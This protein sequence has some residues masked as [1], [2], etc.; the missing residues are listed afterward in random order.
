VFDR[1]HGALKKQ[2]EF[3]MASKQKAIGQK[4]PS[5]TQAADLASKQ[6]KLNALKA[7]KGFD[8]IAVRMDRNGNIWAAGNVKQREEPYAA[9][10]QSFQTSNFGIRPKDQLTIF[11]TIR[12]VNNFNLV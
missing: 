6:N 11:E 4:K 8:T 5:K 3:E 12:K 1:R 9:K 7:E 10:K 2:L